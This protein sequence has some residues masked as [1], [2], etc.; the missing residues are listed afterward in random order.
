M[1]KVDFREMGEVL[2]AEKV[3]I[4]ACDGRAVSGKFFFLFLHFPTNGLLFF[5]S[6]WCAVILISKFDIEFPYYFDIK[7]VKQV[8]CSCILWTRLIIRVNIALIS[9][10]S[11]INSFAY[12]SD[13]TLWLGGGI[14]ED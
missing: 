9:L 14:S 7:E 6:H 2:F 10:R 4:V 3:K 5:Y 11:E 1:E 8:Y 13:L 12:L